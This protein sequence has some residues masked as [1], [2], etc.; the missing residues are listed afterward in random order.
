MPDVTLS[1][2][3]E[4]L[5]TLIHD[6]RVLRQVWSERANCGTVHHDLY[7][8]DE[9]ESP[10]QSALACCAACPVAQECLATALYHEMDDDLRFGWWGGLSPEERRELWRRLQVREA[11]FE[12]DPHP[13]A[14]AR[15]L[16]ARR[17]TITSIAAEL[18][19][20][21]RTVYRILAA[22]AA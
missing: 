13:V 16:R 6:P 18:G 20:S 10:P 17:H 15:L 21:E 1:R 4:E 3:D 22:D 11:G 7:F 19:C 12:T 9:G 14:R 8:P 2:D 5:V